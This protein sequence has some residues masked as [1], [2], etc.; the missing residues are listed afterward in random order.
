MAGA[1][2]IILCIEGSLNSAQR[3]FHFLL[4][5]LMASFQCLNL[6]LAA[7]LVVGCKRVTQLC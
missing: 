3:E 1:P 5:L 6:V 4:S 2:E 7:F